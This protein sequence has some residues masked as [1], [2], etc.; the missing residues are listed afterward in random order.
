MKIP[1]QLEPL[2]TPV[3][4]AEYRRAFD[5]M[6]RDHVDGV[7]IGVGLE[8]YTH[9]HLLGQLAQQYHLLAFAAGGGGALTATSAALAGV[10]STTA[11]R[12]R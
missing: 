3:N 6:Q 11:A 10:T 1:L 9:H 8:S 5:A 4:E 12:P 7:L 2:Q